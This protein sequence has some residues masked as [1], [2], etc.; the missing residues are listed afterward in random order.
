MENKSYVIRIPEDERG[1]IMSIF[2][3]SR[4]LFLSGTGQV[5]QGQTFQNDLRIA[6]S[7]RWR[8]LANQV[9]RPMAKRK[10]SFRS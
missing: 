9:Q 10:R 7:F 6:S 1:A 8:W 3:F 2:L 5:F 4:L